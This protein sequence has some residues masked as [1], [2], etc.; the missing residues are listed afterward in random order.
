LENKYGVYT[1]VS[2]MREFIH[3]VVG[4]ELYEHSPYKSSEGGEG[5]G[6]NESPSRPR[7]FRCF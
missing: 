3:S 5:G 4:D 6:E 1:K 2:V 7:P